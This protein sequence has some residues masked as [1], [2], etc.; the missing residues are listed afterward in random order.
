MLARLEHD[1]REHHAAAEDD[2]FSVLDD[3][4]VAGYR[5]FLA[6]IYHFEYAVESQLVVAEDLPIRFVLAN[7]RTGALGDDL[8]ALG[9][10][11]SVTNMF[12]RR[13]DRPRFRDALEGFG[14]MYV[15]QR[16]TLQ[17]GALL[18]A[19]APHLRGRMQIASRYLTA[20]ANNV[21]GLWHELGARLDVAA[22][23]PER[24]TQIV[25]AAR[26]AFERQHAWFVE[27]RAHA[28]QRESLSDGAL[29]RRRSRW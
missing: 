27:A 8:L 12:A 17:N 28:T 20:N 22:A 26:R 4:T 15:V 1:T 19:L 5:R 14:W 13:I 9:S 3:A 25:D 16:N 2:R 23:T 7:L 24:G 10:E 11:S 29:A 21:H 6:T 18:R